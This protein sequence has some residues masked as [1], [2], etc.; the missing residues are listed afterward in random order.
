MK[1]TMEQIIEGI[2]IN[3]LFLET[4]ETRNSDSLDFHKLSVWS[5][6]EALET[7]YRA[8]MAA[9]ETQNTPEEPE[10]MDER[11]KYSAMPMENWSEGTVGGFSFQIKHFDDGSYYGID[12]G[13]ISKLEIRDANNNIRVNYDRGWDI[14]PAKHD[15]ALID[16]YAAIIAEFN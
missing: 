7:S 15:T 9:A 16:A 4:L 5:I 2:G 6:K 13:R 12:Y 11:L 8:G 14:L 10:P 3:I 1:K